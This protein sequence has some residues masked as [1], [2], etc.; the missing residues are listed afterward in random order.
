MNAA[1][2]DL[3]PHIVGDV[4]EL[5][6]LRES[7]FDELYAAA[8]DPLIWEQHPDDRHRKDVFRR[9]FAEHLASGGALVAIDRRDERI[10]GTSRYHGYDEGRS[11]IE[12]GWTFLVRSLWGGA[13]NAEMKWLMLEHAFRFVDT[14]IFAIDPKNIR[15]QRS[16]E[17]IGAVRAR[18]RTVNGREQLI[19]EFKRD[20]V[21]SPR[22]H[23]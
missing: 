1:P 4:L 10:V 3:Q 8:S 19:Y 16:V 11:E 15:S 18:T 5:R 7:D 23:A 14:V 9:F 20:G 22:A 21:R 13:F 6:P 2:F 17:K 12:I